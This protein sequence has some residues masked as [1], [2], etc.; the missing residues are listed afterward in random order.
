MAHTAL[1]N[2]RT[3]IQANKAAIGKVREYHVSLRSRIG[4]FLASD[5]HK[6][7]QS[8]TRNGGFNGIQPV[9]FER[10]AYELSLATQALADVDPPLAFDIARI[11][12]RQQVFQDDEDQMSAAMFAPGALTTNFE[13]LMTATAVYLNQV[14]TTEPALIKQYDEVL[15]KIDAAL[16]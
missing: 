12:T 6:T 8:F 2:F 7:I 11:Y 4:Q 1:R 10:T 16:H 5:G 15:P 9:R 14:V 3:E 13:G